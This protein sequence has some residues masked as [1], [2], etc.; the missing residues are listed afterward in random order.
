MET[1]FK[2]SV[3]V[4]TTLRISILKK[5]IVAHL[6]SQTLTSFLLLFLDVSQASTRVIY[7]SYLKLNSQLS[8]VLRT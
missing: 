6:P 1:A 7:V 2:N 8:P 3:V 5:K 4:V